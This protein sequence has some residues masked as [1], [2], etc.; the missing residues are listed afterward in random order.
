MKEHTNI[1]LESGL[2]KALTKEAKDQ[3]RSFTNYV[4]LLLSTHQDRK[5]VKKINSQP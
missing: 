2:K 1:R 3:H 5:I 4:E